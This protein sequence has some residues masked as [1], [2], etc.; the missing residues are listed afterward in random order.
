MTGRATGILETLRALDDYAFEHFVA[1]VWQERQGWATEVAQQSRDRG[2]DVV[3]EPPGLGGA[4]TAVQAKRYAAG[5]KVGA[6]KVR[7]YNSITDE[8]ADIDSVTIVTTSSFTSDALKTAERFGIKCIDGQD[9]VRVIQR[10]DA[11][12]IVE[13]YA[14]GRPE[15]W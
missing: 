8:V 9:L 10:D 12:E 13:W 3:G 1:D 14:A 4:K 15:D 2:I 5:N 11:M 7:E 6:P